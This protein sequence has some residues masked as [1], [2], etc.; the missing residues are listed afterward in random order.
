[1]ERERERTTE[2]KM[3][4]RKSMDKS[5]EP[6]KF[7]APPHREKEGRKKKTSILFS[8]VLLPEQQTDCACVRF[9][10]VLFKRTSVLYACI[11]A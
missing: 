1:M 5:C 9:I 6:Q 8:V 7:C 11:I 2:R 3:G 4:E 10:Y